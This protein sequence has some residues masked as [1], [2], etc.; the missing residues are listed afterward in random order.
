MKPRTYLRTLINTFSSAQYYRDI[1]N[2]PFTF[3]L[4]FFVLS[5]IFIGIIA[6]ILF[7]SVD[8]PR[9]QQIANASLQELQSS[10]PSDLK[11][12]WNGDALSSSAQ[13][14]LTVPYPHAYHPDTAIPFL[15]VL[16]LSAT[17]PAATLDR[18]KTKS[19]L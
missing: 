11:L 18:L 5:Y 6:A 17:D 12:S 10:Y 7:A 14:P 4:R 15:A 16:D 19:V 2:A 1:L 9:Y 8:V 13:Q 3:S